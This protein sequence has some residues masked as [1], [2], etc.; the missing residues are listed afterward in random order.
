MHYI[1]FTE[2]EPRLNAFLSKKLTGER[3][4][5][6]LC[7]RAQKLVDKWFREQPQIIVLGTSGIRI[8]GCVLGFEIGSIKVERWL[9][10]FVHDTYEI[11]KVVPNAIAL[12]SEREVQSYIAEFEGFP[13]LCVRTSPFDVKRWSVRDVVIPAQGT[14]LFMALERAR[15]LGYIN[16]LKGQPC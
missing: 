12:G 5:E 3:M 8:V 14:A 15:A 6:Y 16:H 4:N 11:M 13:H 2:A 10:S 7:K 9:T 1:D